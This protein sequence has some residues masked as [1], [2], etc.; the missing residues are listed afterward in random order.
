MEE[1]RTT[2]PFGETFWLRL[3]QAFFGSATIAIAV[4][5]S[6]GVLVWVYY[7]A[8]L[9]FPRLHISVW[10]ALG[11]SLACFAVR[12]ILVMVVGALTATANR[13][14]ADSKSA[15]ETPPEPEKAGDKIWWCPF[16]GFS[17]PYRDAET[18]N[19]HTRLHENKMLSDWDTNGSWQC[20]ECEFR[21]DKEERDKQMDHLNQH[22]S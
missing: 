17:C 19:K 16:C 5:E 18:V 21:C 20:P 10:M 14:S 2:L 12:K 7:L 8:G 11:I 1:K 4:L 6:V 22:Y 9:V 3:V 15:P 13:F